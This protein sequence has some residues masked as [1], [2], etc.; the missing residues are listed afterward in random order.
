MVATREHCARV[1]TGG[2]GCLFYLFLPFP[3]D[4]E[5]LACEDIICLEFV[6]RCVWKVDTVFRTSAFV[7]PTGAELRA[8]LAGRLRGDV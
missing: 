5:S 3:A 1:R 2:E 6:K 8:V 7:C 4:R